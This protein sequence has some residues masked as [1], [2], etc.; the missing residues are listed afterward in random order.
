MANTLELIEKV[1]EKSDR[2]LQSPKVDGPYISKLCEYEDETNSPEVTKS[3][4]SNVYKAPHYFISPQYKSDE[5]TLSKILCLGKVQSGKTVFFL[6]CIAV[7]FDN[8]YDLA[9]IIGGTKLKLKNQNFERVRDEFANNPKVKVLDLSV[10]K[11]EEIADNLSKGYKVIAVLLK[12]PSENVNLGALK[13][14]VELNPSVPSIVVDD[15]GDEY[16]PGAPKSKATNSRAGRTHDAISDIVYSLKI[17]TYLSVTAT[18]QANFLISTIDAL[19]PD[20]AVLVEPGNGYIGGISFHDLMSNPHCVQI[21]DS[22]DF[23]SSVPDS[24]ENALYFFILAA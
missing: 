9:Y 11:D 1:D 3:I 4:L 12:N 24:F 20:F 16:S 2:F 7:A 13:R 23:S 5:P 8:G 18:P 15:E 6:A 21:D 19:S 10:T 22:D 14:L 17:C